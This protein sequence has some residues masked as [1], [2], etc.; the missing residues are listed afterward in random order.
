MQT[1]GDFYRGIWHPAALVVSD[2]ERQGIRFNSEAAGPL[3]VQTKQERESLGQQLAFWFKPGINWGSWQQLGALL[4]DELNLP[5]SPIEGTAKAPKPAK[6]GSR[7]TGEAALLWLRANT[8]DE[9]IKTGLGALL[10]WKKARKSES[11][12]EALPQFVAKDGRIHCQLGFAGDDD[13]PIGTETGRLSSKNPNLQQIP[14]DKRFRNAF[15]AEEGNLLVVLDMKGLEWRIAAHIVAHLYGDYS[16]VD[17][18]KAGVDPHS[19]TAE[20]MGVGDREVGKILNYSINYGKSPLGLSLQLGIPKKRAEE[21]IRAFF[22]ARPGLAQFHED[23]VAY[24]RNNGFVRSLLGR[25]RYLDFAGLGRKAERQAKNVIQPAA[26]DVMVAA[27][28]RCNSEPHQE[29]IDLGWYN[30]ELHSLGARM[31][32]QVHDEIVFEV[33]AERAPRAREVAAQAMEAALVGIRDDFRCPLS[34]EGGVGETWGT[35]K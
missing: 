17:E 7:P 22:K 24:A 20:K 23:I 35:A 19:A 25:Y 21:Y 3:L 15:C 27:M 14:K 30:E 26:T 2:M 10:A 1:A 16:L 34:V 13:N 8:R 18:I 5:V 4:H 29:L 11:F 32:L 31:L 28:L 9:G 33:P 6:K 12:W